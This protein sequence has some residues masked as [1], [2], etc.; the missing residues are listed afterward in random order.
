M[1]RIQIV[2]I[3][4][5]MGLVRHVQGVPVL[6]IPLEGVVVLVRWFPRP[7][8]LYRVRAWKK[9]MIIFAQPVLKIAIA[10]PGSVL[11]PWPPVREVHQINIERGHVLRM[12]TAI[13]PA[14]MAKIAVMDIVQLLVKGMCIMTAGEEVGVI[15]INMAVDMTVAVE[16]TKTA[17]LVLPCPRHHRRR[18]AAKE[19]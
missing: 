11:D 15:N 12:T 14:I 9:K 17:M 3:T 16:V 13:I 10:N 6:V 4:P 5:S 19:T 2:T 7:L 18:F 1:T 8:I